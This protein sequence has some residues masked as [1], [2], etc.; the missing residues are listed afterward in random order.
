MAQRKIT[1]DN[2]VGYVGKDGHS[3][4]EQTPLFSKARKKNASNTILSEKNKKFIKN[5]AGEVFKIKK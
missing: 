2:I 4:S 5:V 1:N 3:H